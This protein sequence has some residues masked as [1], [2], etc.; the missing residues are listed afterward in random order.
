MKITGDSIENFPD[1][2]SEPVYVR[3]ESTGNKTLGFLF[4]KEHIRHI[5]VDDVE[6]FVLNAA[7]AVLRQD[8]ETAA[9]KKKMEEFLEMDFVAGA[10]LFHID[11][12]YYFKKEPSSYLYVYMAGKWQ[13]LTDSC[14]FSAG[15]LPVSYIMSIEAIPEINKLLGNETDV[16][17]IKDR[18][19][20]SDNIFPCIILNTGGI[21]DKRSAPSVRRQ[22]PPPPAAGGNNKTDSKKLDIIIDAPIESNG[23]SGDFR[24]FRWFGEDFWIAYL[25]D[26][27]GRVKDPGITARIAGTIIDNMLTENRITA[28]SAD[29]LQPSELKHLLLLSF[30]KIHDALLEE[31]TGSQTQESTFTMLI[32]HRGTAY[33]DFVGNSPVIFWD[34]QKNQLNMFAEI[35]NHKGMVSSASLLEGSGVKNRLDSPMRLGN[36]ETKINIIP[37]SRPV[38]QGDLLLLCSDGLLDILNPYR[39]DHHCFRDLE[40]LKDQVHK[41]IFNTRGR[42]K[43]NVLD[44]DVLVIGKYITKS[45]KTP[46]EETEERWEE[47]G[48]RLE[49]IEKQLKTE[50]FASKEALKSASD[51]VLTMQTQVNNI[52]KR[53]GEMGTESTRLKAFNETLAGLQKDLKEIDGFVH[54]IKADVRDLIKITNTQQKDVELLKDKAVSKS[55][56]K[57]DIQRLV[58]ELK[59]YP[60]FK[61]I[62]KEYYSKEKIDNEIITAIHRMQEELKKHNAFITRIINEKINIEERENYRELLGGKGFKQG[63]LKFFGKLRSI[64]KRTIFLFGVTLTL[65]LVLII[66]SILLNKC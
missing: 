18:L 2:E 36:P 29:T 28:A 21:A 12:F 62:Q 38:K 24:G 42:S 54:N 57:S 43:D 47:L 13:T 20:D 11:T 40:V 19:I 33:F 61:Q 1:S 50:T 23:V 26:T 60:S 66:I 49:A 8:L 25:G 34:N 16:V 15:N 30:S 27:I 55:E 46:G 44:D 56:Y 5:P 59:D 39:L 14:E 31:Y 10:I 58:D 53:V 22:A 35:K 4:D 3:Q 9:A 52:E 51:K 48:N 45:F 32:F 41:A 65:G 63:F 64:P 17:R 6:T 37:Y 7:N